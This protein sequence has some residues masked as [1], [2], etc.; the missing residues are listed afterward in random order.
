MEAY[1][2]V[3]QIEVEEHVEIV[4]KDGKFRT[5]VKEIVKN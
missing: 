4:L 3:E 1:K 2:S 5:I